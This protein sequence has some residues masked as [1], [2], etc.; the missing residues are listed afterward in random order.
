M[1]LYLPLQFGAVLAVVKQL[2][3]LQIDKRLLQLLLV[4]LVLLV[5]QVEYLLDFPSYNGVLIP[6]FATFVDPLIALANPLPFDLL[7]YKQAQ[8]LFVE[9]PLTGEVPVVVVLQ[10]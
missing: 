3:L 1:H 10:V 5:L 4:L 8:L 2:H 6:Y 7:V 9:L